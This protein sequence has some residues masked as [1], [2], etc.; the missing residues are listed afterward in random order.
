VRI[1]VADDDPTS[2][3]ITRM[4]L[5]NAGHEFRT[6]TDGAA[7]WESFKSYRPDVIISDWMMP[8]MTGLDLCRSVRAHDFGTYAYFVMLT[9]HGNREAVFEGMN[10]GADD[11]LVKPLDPDDLR[12][13]LIAAERVTALHCQLSR[14][15][16][17]LEELNDELTKLAR[18]DPLTSLANRRALVEDL[19]VIEARVARYGHRYCVAL[20]DVD[21]FKAYNDTYGHQGGDE[22]LARVAS[23]LSQRARSGDAF[24]RYGGDELLCIL[25]EQTLDSGAI[26]V[27]R[28]RAAVERLAIPHSGSPSSVVTFS[29][30]LA[31]LDAA[32]PRSAAEALREADECLYRAKQLG[33]NRIAR[34][35]AGNGRSPEGARNVALR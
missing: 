27:E 26:A 23:Q 22:V 28:M 16:R 18:R 31:V 24:Y 1:L 19:E 9:S 4:V 17:R 11:Y 14:Q 34:T 2:L 35:P 25:P 12:A 10:A 5:R 33:R 30:G 29:A 32:H 20:I 8:G 6:A 7:A 3:L 15:Q 21:F 13:R